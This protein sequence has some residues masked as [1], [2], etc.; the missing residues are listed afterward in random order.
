[1][2]Q[3]AMTTYE[4]FARKAEKEIAEHEKAVQKASEVKRAK[5][6]KEREEKNRIAAEA[7]NRSIKATCPFDGMVQE[8]EMVMSGQRVRVVSITINARP[9][10]VGVASGSFPIII[11]SPSGGEP[12]RISLTDMREWRISDLT[13]KKNVITVGLEKL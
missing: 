10:A 6:K 2:I 8:A 7:M 4:W 3:S 9:N 11:V 1:M 12:Y 5:A 13:F